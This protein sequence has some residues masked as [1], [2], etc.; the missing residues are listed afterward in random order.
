MLRVV[1][2]VVG[3]IVFFA[4]AGMAL[5]ALG[6]ALWPEYAAAVAD[7]AYTLPMLWSRL[8][9]GAVAIICAT[10]LALMLGKQNVRTGFLVGVALLVL[11]V[12]WHVN[13]WNEYPAWYHLTWFAIILPAAL[14]GGRLATR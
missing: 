10:W 3:G 5:G 11:S 6:K 9:G 12:V 4:L 2:S 13:I 7:R 8:V 14:L 1:A